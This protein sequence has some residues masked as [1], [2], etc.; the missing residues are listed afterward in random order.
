MGMKLRGSR[1]F[2]LF[3]LVKDIQG[4]HMIVVAYE[5]IDVWSIYIY[6]WL[7]IIL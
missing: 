7:V 4:V 5:N 2:Q 3:R 6:F 1:S